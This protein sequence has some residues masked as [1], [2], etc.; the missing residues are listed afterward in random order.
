MPQHNDCPMY[1]DEDGGQQALAVNV[2]SSSLKVTGFVREPGHP[3]QRQMYHNWPLSA[4]EPQV[5]AEMLA[6]AKIR[7]DRLLCVVHRYVHGGTVLPRCALLDEP[8]LAQL[9]DTAALAPLH[10]P[11]ALVW[12][13]EFQALLPAAVQVAVADSAFFS[14]LPQA[15][16]R[17]PLPEE[18]VSGHALR[19]YGFHGLAHS[20][21]WRRWSEITGRTRGRLITLQLGGGSSA[22]AIVDGRPLDTSMGFTPLEGVV[23]GHRA[24][25]LDPGLLLYLLRNAGIDAA[26]LDEI[27]NRR[28][29]LVALAGT[30][31]MRALLAREDDEA[32]LALDIFCRSAR[33]YIGAYL[34]EMG[35]ADALVFSGGIGEHNP[36]VRAQILAPLAALGFQLDAARNSAANSGEAN[37]GARG[38]GVHVLPADEAGELLFNAE[39]LLQEEDL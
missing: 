23:M 27:L 17:Y 4:A 18:L 15:A 3:W 16:Q 32:K 10:N 8:L 26:E 33:K 37:I 7:E 9:Q 28:S 20:A 14:D 5:V 22:A 35:G 25:D 12:M 1:P 6:G 13:R 36:E 21:M 29:G 39:M 11:P 24:G 34:A 38:T 19:R 31:D 30:G 2:G